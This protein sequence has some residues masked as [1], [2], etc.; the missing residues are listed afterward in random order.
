MVRYTWSAL[1]LL[2][3]TGMS[4]SGFG[5]RFSGYAAVGLG[6]SLEDKYSAPTWQVE[7]SQLAR[8]FGQSSP[9]MKCLVISVANGVVLPNMFVLMRKK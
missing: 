3:L 7:S 2:M 9:V 4:L 6:S 5:Q 1:L 8:T